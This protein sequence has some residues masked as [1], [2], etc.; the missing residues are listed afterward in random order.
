LSQL[1]HND[2]YCR[3][4]IPFL[5]EEYFHEETERI[6]YTTIQNHLND[7][8]TLPTTE[9]LSITINQSV[10][11]NQEDVF[12]NVIEYID[13]L[14]DNEID[15]VWLL[16][17]T[18]KFCQEKS[19]YN[20]I[21]ESIQ[22][23][24]GKDK[25][26]TT[27][28]IP[29]ILSKALS[30]SFDNHIGHDWIEDFSERYDFYH[31]TEN[32]VPFDLEYLNLITK[33]GLPQKTLSCILAGTGVGKSL[34]MCHFAASNLM[35][36]KRV[37]YI[38]L[39]MAEERIAER[40]DANL[41]DVSLKDLENLPKTSYVKKVERIRDKTEGRLI[42]KEY[43][44]ATAGA[45]HF[46]HLMNELRLK[47]NFVPDIVY[48]DYLNICSSM[49]LK[50]GANV[51]S[52][53][54][55]KSIAEEIRGLAVEKNIP[56]VTATQTTR[57]GFSNSDPGLE[58]TSESFGL[59]ATVDLMLALVSSEELEGLNQIMIK[60][61]KN[62]FND[63]VANKRFVVGVDRAKMRLYDVENSA[64]EELIH[65]VPVMNKTEFGDRYENDT[66]KKFATL[67]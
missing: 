10:W 47:R 53:T 14:N 48:I 9:I 39:E 49:R 29:E 11:K 32:R 21:M 43:P 58:D 41:L 24:D 60:Q 51:N 17:K 46:R 8:N 61:L 55:I 64:Q 19:V 12:D 65:D 62:R 33:G 37:L 59:P 7:Y 45:G 34:A 28:A 22:I 35:D 1:L 26:K 66:K 54:Y 36:N 44:T 4:A 3:K 16:E 63:P 25:D 31:K 5:K 42:I 50:Y 52:Y 18:E 27:G 2:D 13:N 6:L 38:T 57:S 40:I 20:A 67:R 15:N 30:V 56:I 23:I